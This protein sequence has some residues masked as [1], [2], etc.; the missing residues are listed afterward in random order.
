MKFRKGGR[1]CAAD[2]LSYGDEALDVVSNYEYLGVTLQ[3]TLTFTEHVVKKKQKCFAIIGSLR[4][5]QKVSVETGLKIFNMKIAPILT[6]ALSEISCFLSLAQLKTIDQ[7]KA[8]FVKKLIGVHISASSTL[9]LKIAEIGSFTEDLKTK[10]RFDPDVI[11]EYE[12]M[13]V[14]KTNELLQNR[15][16]EG[17]AFLCKVWKMSNQSNRHLLTRCTVHG[18][19]HFLCSKT[20]CYVPEATCICINCGQ[21]ASERYHILS[22]QNIES[23]QMYIKNKS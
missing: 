12:T 5:L 17:P 15:F 23:W 18:F 22:C 1:L 13:R 9:A 11:Q 7:I 4:H 2:V 21:R 8:T 6:Y 16:L 10:Y 19:H 3:Q 20:R 14:A